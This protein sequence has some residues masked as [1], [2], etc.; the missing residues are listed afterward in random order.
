MTERTNTETPTNDA[1]DANVADSTTNSPPSASDVM[2]GKEG[3]DKT[4]VNGDKAKDASDPS[5]TKDETDKTKTDSNPEGEE[6]K[7][8]E[9]GEESEES[10]DKKVDYADLKL[11][12]D[13]PEG[14]TIDTELFDSVKAI[15]QKHNIRPEAMQELVDGY[16]AT[17]ANAETALQDHWAGV[18][19]GWK[20][21]IK[22]DKEIGGDKYD[23]SVERAKRAIK[24]Y[25]TEELHDVLESSRLG[26]NPEFVRVFARIGEKISEPQG[27]DRG[28]GQSQ[29]TT[30]DVLFDNK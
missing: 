6:K 30:A 29:K 3:G 19:Q 24:Q 17:I 25:G 22:T 18:E 16:A 5:N 13:L 10:D 1:T 26:N 14:I 8:G 4:E 21:S 23:A 15:G 7:D 27:F 2:F 28:S 20:D 9:E 12:E 11:P